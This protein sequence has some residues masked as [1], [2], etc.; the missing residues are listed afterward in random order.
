MNGRLSRD[1]RTVYLMSYLPP[2]VRLGA[3]DAATG[4]DRFP[5]PSH[6]GPGH[7]GPVRST[8]FS[9]DGR[10]LASGGDD[11]RVCLW[12]L[13][14]QPG[15][16][17]APPRLL[18]RHDRPVVAVAF[19]PDGRLLASS[20]IDGTIR[21][22][23]V[24]TGPVMPDLSTSPT[25]VPTQLAFSP[26]GETL[27]AGGAN[28]GVNLWDAKTGKP[29][30]PV[31]WHVGAGHAVAVSPDGRWLG[32]ARL[33]EAVQLID[34]ASG[35][36][37]PTFRGGIL[38]SRLAFSPDSR[39]LAAASDGSGPLRLWDFATKAERPVT[40]GTG[41]VLGLAFHPQGDRVA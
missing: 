26:D 5:D 23:D 7:S 27:A 28:G 4:A 22:S 14:N 35:K 21:L 11:G 34:L 40:G 13:T 38:V 10:T 15:G 1:G 33:A 17:F 18:T 31:R 12:D 36:R 41:P 19:S 25:L 30:D 16:A 3:Y 24:A 2:E 20:S 6:S 32:S 39:T 29:K 8:A 9:P 37:V